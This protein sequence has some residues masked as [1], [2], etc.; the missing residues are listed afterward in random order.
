MINLMA[1]KPNHVTFF[2]I[3]AAPAIALLLCINHWFPA[4]LALALYILAAASDWLDGYLARKYNDTSLLG[5]VF[6]IIADKMLVI[7]VL[8][9]LAYNGVLGGAILP[10]LAIVLRE[11]F[12]AGL[13]EYAARYADEKKEAEPDA[14]ALDAT[15]YAKAKTVVQMVAIG[16]LVAVP[17]ILPTFVGA[18]GAGLLWIAAALSLYTGY[19]YW[20][21]ARFMPPKSGS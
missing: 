19:Q 20:Q 21:A 6:D 18:I 10:A 2:R 17:H 13:R 14:S 4:L 15:Q 5:K 12:I 1:L 8:L 16:L 7:S 3:C 9:S 11:I